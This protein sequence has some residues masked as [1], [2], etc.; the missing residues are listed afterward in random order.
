MKKLPKSLL[1]YVK[2][3]CL[4]TP[5]FYVVQNVFKLPILLSQPL[6]WGAEVKVPHFLNPL[7]Y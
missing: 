6:Q 1:N 5:V 4:E 2:N 3:L 7:Y